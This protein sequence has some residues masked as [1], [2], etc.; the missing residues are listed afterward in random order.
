[1]PILAGAALFPRDDVFVIPDEGF[2]AG[3]HCVLPNRV[4]FR[5]QVGSALQAE[6]RVTGASAQGEQTC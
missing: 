6:Y 3:E 1:M 5:Y 4:F 2:G